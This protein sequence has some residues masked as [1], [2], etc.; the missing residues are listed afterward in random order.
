MQDESIRLFNVAAQCPGTM[1]NESIRLLRA[2]AY[3]LSILQCK[4][5]NTAVNFSER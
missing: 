2:A 5:N 4:Q 1:Q 3:C